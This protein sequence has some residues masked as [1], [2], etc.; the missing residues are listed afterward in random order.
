MKR[1]GQVEVKVGTTSQPKR[2]SQKLEYLFVS[3][4]NANTMK[5]FDRYSIS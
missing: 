4:Y 2:L 1:V 3:Q 5:N